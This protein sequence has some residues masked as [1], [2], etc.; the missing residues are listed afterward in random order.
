MQASLKRTPELVSGPVNR[1]RSNESTRRSCF[2]INVMPLVGDGSVNSRTVANIG[3][4]AQ[5]MIGL[6]RLD[7]D[8]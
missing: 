6:P 3:L 4:M 5:G 8:S 1:K 7:V 2:V